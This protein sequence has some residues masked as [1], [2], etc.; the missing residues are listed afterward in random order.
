MRKTGNRKKEI[1]K[2][3]RLI[4]IC[5]SVSL[6]LGSMSVWAFADES[7]EDQ[8]NEPAVVEAEPDKTPAPAEDKKVDDSSDDKAPA[9]DD[10]EGADLDADDG[11]DV[12]VDEDKDAD[13]DA[14]GED[15]ADVDDDVDADTD[16]DPEEPA[17]EGNKQDSDKPSQDSEATVHGEASEK[18]YNASIGSKWFAGD[19][20]DYGLLQ[21]NYIWY[22]VSDDSTV[23]RSTI[24]ARLSGPSFS[25]GRW[26][27]GKVGITGNSG[28]TRD[29]TV[30]VAGT[31]DNAPV[32]LKAASGG[33]TKDNPYVL[34]PIYHTHAWT[35]TASGS[36]ATIKCTNEDCP[37]ARTDYSV[38]I[39]APNT[40]LG[41]Q[42]PI[43]YDGSAK[44]ASLSKTPSLPDQTEITVSG[45]SYTG[46]DTEGTAYES[47]DAPVDAGNYTA[48][49]SVTL[50]DTTVAI[51]VSFQIRKAT[52][53]PLGIK[54]PSAIK[55]GLTDLNEIILPQGGE[56]EICIAGGKTDKAEFVYSID[57][58]NYS[59]GVPTVDKPGEYTISYKLQPDKNH[60][61][62][63]ILGY[64]IDFS[65]TLQAKVMNY[66]FVA[67]AGAE[68]DKITEETLVFEAKRSNTDEESV[69]RCTEV[70]V[71]GEALTEGTDY[72][73][74]SGSVVIT[75]SADYL[76]SLKTGS[77]TIKLV[78][79]DPYELET[80]FTVK[81]STPAP[82]TGEYAS[83]LIL[84]VSGM[85]AAA[86]AAFVV[87]A[88]QEAEK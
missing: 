21:R 46:A 9:A 23:F 34:V 87:K 35:I 49:A 41:I 57:G 3:K 54:E 26:S 53:M 88:R 72:T 40:V 70:S 71:D 82:Q 36:K 16:I 32:G 60:T 67:G 17:D 44:K 11:A 29:Y 79:A 33:G 69:E 8:V 2:A 55:D 45:I 59:K 20:L 39:S 31:S 25:N 83:G 58:Q 19:V 27:F 73:K 51:S 81:A 30:S 74:T 22:K 84:I 61:L 78:F 37:E 63:D 85:M 65:G 28:T 50:G 80:S 76:K 77:H 75:L 10:Q 48:T 56:V 66:E 68:Y 43:F 64:E 12:V 15:D 38:T 62:V 7:E 14:D 5:L 6:V 4:A 47:T 1:S 18:S 86:G 13:V 52:T 42:I 24:G